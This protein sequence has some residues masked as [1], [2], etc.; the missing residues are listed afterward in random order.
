M[1]LS[2][3]LIKGTGSYEVKQIAPP[4]ESGQLMVNGDF[5]TGDSTGWNTYQCDVA[6][7]NNEASINYT[8]FSYGS[9]TQARLT[10]GRYYKHTF[11]LKKY[12]TTT[13][14]NFFDGVETALSSVTTDFQKFIFYRKATAVDLGITVS[15]L[16]NGG[17]I[18]KSYSVEELPEGYPLMDKGMKYLECTAVGSVVFPTDQAYGEWEWDWYKTELGDIQVSLFNDN[19]EAGSDTGR[20]R[21]DVLGSEGIRFVVD[22]TVLTST[23]TGYIDIN[24]W[25]RFKVTRTLDG[26]FYFYI[27]GGS[28]GN[29]DWTLI[30]STFTNPITNN[31]YNSGSYLIVYSKVGDRISTDISFKAVK[32]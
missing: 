8:T 10:I 30:E 22:D 15:G 3:Q 17:A 19:K 16:S 6:V 29:N 7:I 21:L 13:A 31:T 23:S 1:D 24:T 25:Y 4:V 20:Y 18:L 14:I 5:A 32:Q 2:G 28:F 27:K 11:Y 9:L 12:G 26:E